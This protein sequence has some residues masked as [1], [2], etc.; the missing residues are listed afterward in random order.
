MATI[1]EKI[2]GVRIK[3]G[4]S[5]ESLAEAAK[6]NLRTIQRIENN[7]TTPRGKTLR[8]IFNA[9]EIEVVENKQFIISKYLMWSSLLTLLLIVGTCLG[10]IRRFKMYVNEEKVYIRFTGWNGYTLLND[11]NFYNWL[12]SIACISVGFIVIGHSLRLIKNKL[13]YIVLQTLLLLLYVLGVIQWGFIQSVELRPG[14]FIVIVTTILL[15][16][17]Y[18]RQKAVK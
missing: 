13:K 14:L 8:L 1:G 7:E 4:L 15:L 18:R 5:Q 17:T 11:V 10:W 16:I 2:R 9:L 12:V 3:R 6:I